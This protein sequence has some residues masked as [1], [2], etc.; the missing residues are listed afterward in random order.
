[1]T[2]LDQAKKDKDISEDEHKR[3]SVQVDE[4]MTKHR[5]TVDQLARAKETEIMT[6]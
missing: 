2:E 5:A 6:V 4:N 3:Y 1:M